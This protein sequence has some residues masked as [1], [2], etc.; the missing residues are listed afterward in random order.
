MRWAIIMEIME[1]WDALLD[2]LV[3]SPAVANMATSAGG[4]VEFLLRAERTLRA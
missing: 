1:H 2:L 4:S 3:E